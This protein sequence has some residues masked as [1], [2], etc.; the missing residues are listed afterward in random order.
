[1]VTH[2]AKA[3]GTYYPLQVEEVLLWKDLSATAVKVLLYLKANDPFG[4]R[5][6]EYAIQDIADVFGVNRSTVSRAIKSLGAAG[7]INYEITR[8][9][10]KATPG[11]AP[12]LVDIN[13]CAKMHDDS[14]QKC[15]DLCKNAPDDAKMHQTVQNC[16]I[17]PP[18]AR[19]GKGS[20]TPHTLK[21][22]KTNHTL[23]DRSEKEEKK[24]NFG[25]SISSDSDSQEKINPPASLTKISEALEPKTEL[26]I[27]D[28][29][30]ARLPKFDPYFGK[31]FNPQDLSW[32]WLPD[33]DWKLE[34]KLDP[35]FHDWLAKDFNRRFEDSKKTI[36]DYKSDAKAF[37]RNDP[38]RLPDM[39]EKY[40]QETLYRYQETKA[41]IDSG[42]NV[43]LEYQQALVDRQRAVT[44]LNPCTEG[45]N[46]QAY[47]LY[48]A[49][50]QEQI[51]PLLEV[52]TLEQM[53]KEW[54]SLQKSHLGEFLKGK[55]R[56]RMIAKIAEAGYEISPR[57]EVFNPG[58]F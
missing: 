20:E 48:E 21:T 6:V 16:T 52:S 11:K 44:T 33:G 55:L 19:Q 54:T 24:G 42:M 18:E 10:I 41:A 36:F 51:E 3:N 12:K 49:P 50:R 15:T 39:W 56:E 31:N 2:N 32:G 1:M 58:E 28:K 57:N 35:I 9:T 38:Q 23:S 53:Q 7:L 30:S 29:S 8:A 46:H 4:D 27:E 37:L 14:V 43:D 17:R 5:A 47:Q 45:T 22:N 26:A 34:G 40:Q 25:F 13:G